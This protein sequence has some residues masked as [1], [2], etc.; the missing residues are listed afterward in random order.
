V[1]IVV[2]SVDY[3]D[4]LET[5]LPAWKA[6]FPHAAITV[7]TAP[8]D[9]ATRDVADKFGARVYATDAWW[10]EGRSFNK[11]RALD[12]AFGFV[13]SLRPAPAAGEWCLAVDADVFPRGT[14]TSDVR[15][16]VLYGVP[17]YEARTPEDLQLHL[18][19]GKRLKLIPPRMRGEDRPGDRPRPAH[20][21]ATSETT[22][23]ACLGYFQL[24]RYRDDVLFGDSQTAGGYDRRFA[25]QWKARG[26]AEGLYVIHLG[27]MSRSNW[28]GRTVPRWS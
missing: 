3:A 9:V 27:E 24:F 17:R 14:L 12:E 19:A 21:R 6:T 28:R 4:F 13:R 5:T 23:L 25:N 20:R 18:T 8:R 22:A 26:V 11:G 1:R 2:P 7:V 15:P 10:C 16:G